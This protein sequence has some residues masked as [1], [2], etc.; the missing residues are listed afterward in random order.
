MTGPAGY[1]IAI[2]SMKSESGFV[3]VARICSPGTSDPWACG[4]LHTV[5]V[6]GARSPMSAVSDAR[7]QARAW[8][9]EQVSNQLGCV[10]ERNF[11]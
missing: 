6:G 3:G 8:C 10:V 4:P 7:L 11:T 5:R 2:L 1:V 9:L